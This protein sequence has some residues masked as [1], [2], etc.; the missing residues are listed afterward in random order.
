MTNK[1]YD[2]QTRS[3]CYKAYWPRSSK[4]LRSVVATAEK[5][6]HV[7]V[8]LYFLLLLLDWSGSLGFNLGGSGSGSSSYETS[9]G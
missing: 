3:P 4:A 2:T 9:L 8:F 1:H 5:V 6:A 7:H